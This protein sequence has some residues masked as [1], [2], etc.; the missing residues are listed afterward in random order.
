[1]KKEEKIRLLKERINGKP[2]RW[3]DDVVRYFA[4]SGSGKI[5]HKRYY[6]KGNL[7]L[8]DDQNFSMIKRIIEP[9]E[10]VILK[11]TAYSSMRSVY[12][13]TEFVYTAF[14]LTDKSLYTAYKYADQN[15]VTRYSHNKTE[16]CNL[17]YGDDEFS[18][19]VFYFANALEMYYYAEDNIET[20]LNAVLIK[21]GF[22]KE[23]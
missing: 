23:K 21:L 22:K 11:W 14:V 19:F 1:M 13:V 16:Y 12:E 3:E 6:P 2:M 15:S 4:I 8:V 17:N 7:P 18:S 5:L 9:K 10:R 20:K